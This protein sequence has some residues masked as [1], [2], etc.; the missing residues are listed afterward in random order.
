M[1]GGMRSFP[2]A[3]AELGPGDSLGVGMAAL[4]S[5]ATRYYAF[6]AVP[7]ADRRNDLEIFDELVAMFRARAPIPDLTV[8]PEMALELPS[9]AFPSHLLVDDHMV[10]ALDP[11]RIRTLRGQLSQAVGESEVIV[12]RAPWNSPAESEMAS[13]DL[14]ISNAVLE[15]VQ[16]IDVAY[17]SIYDWL[18]P[19]G[20]STHQIDFRSHGLFRGWDGHWACP[21]WLWGL[22]QGRRAYLLNRQPFSQH[23]NAIDR[24]GLS[25]V[26]LRTQERKPERERLSSRFT[27]LDQL[28]RRTSGAFVSLRKP[29][30]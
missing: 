21:D 10:A 18:I 1:E 17:R 9:Y 6:D 20:W 5:G 19:G 11:E 12:Y 30:Q 29:V 2:R 13:I 7:H 26:H 4:I 24:S 14:L 3:I 16:D 25:I 27:K 23:L 22:M 15:H 28:D 8:F